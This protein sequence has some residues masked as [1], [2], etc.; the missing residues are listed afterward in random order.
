M[1]L[2]SAFYETRQTHKC[3][4]LECK[5][6]HYKEGLETHA[7]LGA[8]SLNQKIINMMKYVSYFLKLINAICFV[9]MKY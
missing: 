2:T 1:T 7:I 8:L 6:Q 9:T 4:S 5:Q 3:E